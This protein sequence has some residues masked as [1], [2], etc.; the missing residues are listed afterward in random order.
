MMRFKIKPKKKPNISIMQKES[1]SI[2]SEQLRTIRTSI[3]FASTEK[4]STMVVTSPEPGA[5]KSFISMNLAISFAEQGNKVLLIDA[6]LRRPTV[7]TTLRLSNKLGLSNYLAGQGKL[8]DCLQEITMHENLFVITSGI[9]PPNPAEL[10]SSTKMKE[11]TKIVSDMFD[12]V[13][14]DAPPVL[15]VVDPLI[16]GNIVDGLIL[17]LRS[18]HTDQSDAVQTLDKIKQSKIKMIG[19]VLN[20]R[21]N[22]GDSYKTVYYTRNQK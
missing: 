8:E 10:L 1:N 20:G 6:D 18:E 17:V 21:K 11:F 22:R 12:I 2:S 7:H 13:I 4:L 19:A 5:G 16:I 15:P 14:F 3:Q 9:I